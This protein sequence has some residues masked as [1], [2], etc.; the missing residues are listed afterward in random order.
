[1]IRRH[2]LLMVAALLSLTA[3]SLL[4]QHPQER[5]GLWLALG[6]GYGSA[7]VSCEKCDV[8]D[9]PTGITGFLKIGGTINHQVLLG[10]E[11]DVFSSSTDLTITPLPP[12]SVFTGNLSAA[13]YYYP[14]RKAGLFLKGGAG[15][16]TFSESGNGSTLRGTGFGLLAGIGYDIR[17]GWTFS[18]TPVIDAWYGHPGSLSQNGTPFYTEFNYNVISAGVG[19]TFH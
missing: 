10:G 4:A 1:M 12:R 14:I 11:I 13:I 15:L 3:T 6:A 16:G 18:I 2:P 19:I 9:R 8:P 7:G 17:V 5:N